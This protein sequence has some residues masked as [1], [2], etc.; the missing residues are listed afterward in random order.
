MT[1]PGFSTMEKVTEISGR[2]IGMDIVACRVKELGGA[3]RIR[4]IRGKGVEM[5]MEVP[6]D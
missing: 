1:T 6:I 4:N 3:L 5:T 2:G